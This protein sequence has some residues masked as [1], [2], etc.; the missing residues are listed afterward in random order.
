MLDLNSLHRKVHLCPKWDFASFSFF[1]L[2]LFFFAGGG[3]GDVGDA[4][5]LYSQSKTD[6]ICK[7]QLKVSF[8]CKDSV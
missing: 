8:D 3:L 6:R 1:F 2:F 4:L 5:F 7:F